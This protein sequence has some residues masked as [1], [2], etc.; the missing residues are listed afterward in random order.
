MNGATN[1]DHGWADDEG[2]RAYH[3]AFG[4]RRRVG[5][6]PM[7][8][9]GGGGGGGAATDESEPGGFCAEGVVVAFY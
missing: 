2:I 3:L 5:G 1:S 6:K 4:Y 9:G 8:G 7:R